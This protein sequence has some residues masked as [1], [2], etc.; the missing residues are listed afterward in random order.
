MGSELARRLPALPGHDTGLT[1][2]GRGAGAM[3]TIDVRQLDDDVVRRLKRRAAG[4]DRSLEG[5]VHRILARAVEDDV[6]ARREAFRA[7]AA[8]LWRKA[9]GSPQTPSE[10]LIRDD[11]ES[12]YRVG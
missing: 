12:G 11:R 4:N 2:G 1:A 8:R 10:V 6:A 3:A 7:L 5:E 9:G